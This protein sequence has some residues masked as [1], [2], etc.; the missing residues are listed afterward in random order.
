MGEKRLSS[1]NLVPPTPSLEEHVCATRQRQSRPRKHARTASR[2]SG[3]SSFVPR[4][5]STGRNPDRSAGPRPRR[6]THRSVC[7]DLCR[8][9]IGHRNS[10]R[11]HRLFGEPHHRFSSLV[12]SPGLTEL[13]S[14]QI[15]VSP[16][17]S[18]IP[19]PPSFA[20]A[21]SS[22]GVNGATPS[23]ATSILSSLPPPHPSTVLSP[24]F[25]VPPNAHLASLHDLYAAQIGALVF[26][27]FG[28]G[29]G[30]DMLMSDGVGPSSRPVLVGLGLKPDP[31]SSAP[32]EA[33]E[34]FGLSERDKET[35]AAVM[36]MV[37]DC[38]A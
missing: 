23:S 30:G 29:G 11:A 21:I 7:T 2:R 8:Q 31:D 35:F 4:S 1:L 24:L 10:A 17:P 34:E 26:R 36:E 6:R 20:P 13:S 16:P 14:P 15:Q 9:D 19:A 3:R 22:G 5:A 38:L 37:I 25:G 18:S 27:R 33:A 12:I 28:G 32:E